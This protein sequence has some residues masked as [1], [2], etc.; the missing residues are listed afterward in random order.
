MRSENMISNQQD[1]RDSKRID[2]TI[3]IS[4]TGIMNPDG[5]MSDRDIPSSKTTDISYS[6]MRIVLC[7]FVREKSNIRIEVEHAKSNRSFSLYGEIVWVRGDDGSTGYIAGVR[8]LDINN[9]NIH[10]WCALVDEVASDT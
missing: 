5:S 6:G 10:Q 3:A 8:L 4:V 9:S 1:K 7:K 2:T